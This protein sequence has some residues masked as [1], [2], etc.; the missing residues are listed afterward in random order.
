VGQVAY[1]L[2][3]PSNAK[4]HP[5]VHVSQLKRHIPPTVSVSED[6]SSVCSDPTHILWPERVLQ[7]RSILRG[8]KWIPQLLI[9]W[10]S[11]PPDL[12]TWEDADIF[13]EQVLMLGE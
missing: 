10:R 7:K 9:Q 2:D 5:V 1:K 8:D 13:S 12:A 11:L 4:I 6:L 3:L